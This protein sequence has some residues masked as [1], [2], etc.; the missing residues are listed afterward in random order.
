M[1][2]CACVDKLGGTHSLNGTKDEI[3]MF[4]LEIEGKEGIQAYR[5]LDKDTKQIIETEKGTI[6]GD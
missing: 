5:I 1:L 6:K 2:R 4:L 3:D